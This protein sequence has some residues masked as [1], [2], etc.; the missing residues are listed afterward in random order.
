MATQS[1]TNQ[2]DEAQESGVADRP[3]VRRHRLA[4]RIWHWVNALTVFVMLMSGLMIFNAHPRLYWGEY[5]ANFEHP[6]LMVG[7]TPN[8][9]YVQIGSV[10]FNTTGVIGRWTD[11]HG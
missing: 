9:G 3:L 7:S 2:P 4:T 10:K 8:Q 5:G 11:Q 1:R 6:W